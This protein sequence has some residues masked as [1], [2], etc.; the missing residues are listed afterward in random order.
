MDDGFQR[1]RFELWVTYSLV[2]VALIGLGLVLAAAADTVYA[3]QAL[4][5]CL[6]LPMLILGGVVVRLE[7]L[8]EWILPLTV[9]FP[10]RFAVDALQACVDGGGLGAF[11]FQLASLVMMGAA[12]CLGGIALFRWETQVRILP[13]LNKS[14]IAAALVSWI[15]VG[16][17]GI[18]LGEVAS[19]GAGEGPPLPTG[20]TAAMPPDSLGTPS[21]TSTWRHRPPTPEP[22]SV[23]APVSVTA[24]LTRKA[25]TAGVMRR[26]ERWRALTE[27]DFAALPIGQVPPDA[28]TSRRSRPKTKPRPGARPS[29]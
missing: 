10:G 3:V 6:F 9:F 12:A 28:E 16:S 17:V 4:G 5:Q 11:G 2:A 25:A 15:V 19:R 13:R 14:L 21:I 20:V 27:F 26:P 8:P 23:N 24:F 29:C 7:S 1:I 22:H 18:R